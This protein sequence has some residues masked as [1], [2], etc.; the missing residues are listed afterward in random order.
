MKTNSGRLSTD[1]SEIQSLTAAAAKRL[2]LGQLEVPPEYDFLADVEAD[3]K[4]VAVMCAVARIAKQRGTTFQ[5]QME[6]WEGAGELLK[7][8]FSHQPSR[9]MSCWITTQN[10]AS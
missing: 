7:S 10:Q 2:G 8:K 5:R 3:R 4:L 6:V 9:C 1:T